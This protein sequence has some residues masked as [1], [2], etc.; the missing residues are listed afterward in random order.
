MI[1]KWEV[2]VSS[3][4][5]KW[6][7]AI[8]KFLYLSWKAALEKIFVPVRPQGC[9]FR[10]TAVRKAGILIS[11]AEI[12][13]KNIVQRSRYPSDGGG[14]GPYKQD[15][16]HFQMGLRRREDSHDYN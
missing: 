4:Q 11:V 3:G 14:K 7:K 6:T 15:F 13:V 16:F 1:M 10:R 9:A 12:G 8:I 5:T 2:L